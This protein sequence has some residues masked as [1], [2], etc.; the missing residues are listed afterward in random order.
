MGEAQK[1]GNAKVFN[2]VILGVAAR[3]M[4]FPKDSW[5]QVIKNT[6]PPKTVEKN[7]AAFE[8]GYEI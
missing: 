6:V 5:I 1:L 7:L 4:D 2:T 3:N 8:A